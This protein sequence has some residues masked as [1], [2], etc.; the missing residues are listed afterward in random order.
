MIDWTR[1]YH[2]AAFRGHVE[3]ALKM[4]PDGDAQS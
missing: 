4:M 2:L 3:V 1:T